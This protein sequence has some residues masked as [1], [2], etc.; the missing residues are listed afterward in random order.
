MKPPNFLLFCVDQMQAACMGCA[1]HPMVQTPN[2]DKLAAKGV[3]FCRAYCNNPVCTP[4]RSTMITGKTP[5]QHGC[6]TNG[7]ILPDQPTLPA[8]LAAAG[9]ETH[10]VG[11]LHLQPFGCDCAEG[12]SNW[13]DPKHRL[14]MPYYGF[15]HVDYVGGHVH[16]S[17]GDYKRWLDGRDPKAHDR[18]K[19][20]GTG[21]GECFCID[22][23]PEMHYNN[24][25][26]DRTIA[27][28]DTRQ[29][30]FFLWSSFPDP[31]HPFA[32]CG[33][34]AEMYDPDDVPLPANWREHVDDVPFLAA[35]RACS[36]MHHVDEES[37]LRG[38]I[39]QTLGMITHVDDCIGR[40]LDALEERGLA[41][42]TVIGFMADHGE[43]LGSHGLKMKGVWPHEAL[44]NIPFIWYDPRGTPGVCDDP[45]SLLD[46]VPTVADYA[47]VDTAGFNTRNHDGARAGLPG[48]SLR[49][50]LRGETPA[51]QP[52]L[53]EFDEDVRA[54]RPLCRMRG[55][56][57]GPWKLVRWAGWPEGVL[58]NVEDDPDELHNRWSDPEVA[59]IKAEML[60]LLVDRL[61]ATER[62]DTPRSCFA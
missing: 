47:G 50:R 24:W 41:E 29:T 37:E 36:P 9:Y 45:V 54:D 18:L 27:A 11:K 34:Y 55:L 32:A 23:P 56:V 14:P 21:K 28:L 20:T 59:A 17:F 30:P 48:Q 22:L 2:L 16:Y 3:H 57:H 6:L 13:R 25:I 49:P 15:Q 51:P 8:Q 7:C 4:S 1:G 38:I 10:A 39:A 53:L 19:G 62:F 58:V 35:C 60:D 43:Y 33:L 40:V 31:H 61:A 42:T 46:V 12:M 44:W 26:A 52:A 5:R